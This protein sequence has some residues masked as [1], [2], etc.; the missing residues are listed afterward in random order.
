M[1]HDE[2]FES[3]HEPGTPWNSPNFWF[4]PLPPEQVFGLRQ[5]E[6]LKQLS[7]AFGPL[8]QVPEPVRRPLAAVRRKLCP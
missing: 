4:T 7:P 1:L 8:S 5:S 6:L 3:A 2:V